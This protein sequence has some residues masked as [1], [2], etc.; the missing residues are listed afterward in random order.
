VLSPSSAATSDGLRPFNTR[1]TACAL[2]SDENRRRVRF[3]VMTSSCLRVAGSLA[4]P[5]L[6]G[7]EPH[8]INFSRGSVGWGNPCG[9]GIWAVMGRTPIEPGHADVPAD[10]MPSRSYK[11]RKI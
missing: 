7:G 1:L 9:R 10:P 8:C 6:P 5:P 4:N 3:A 11:A 2:N